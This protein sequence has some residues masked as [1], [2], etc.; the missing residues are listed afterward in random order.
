MEKVS[1]Y[2][3]RWREREGCS[4][5]S[6][7]GQIC[8]TYKTFLLIGFVF[9][10]GSSSVVQPGLEFQVSCLSLLPYYVTPAQWCFTVILLLVCFQFF[11]LE[12]SYPLWDVLVESSQDQNSWE[13]LF[14][15][16]GGWDNTFGNHCPIFI[17]QVIW[18]TPNCFKVFSNVK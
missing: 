16:V 14:P 3:L 5:S 1:F 15:L 18:L 2:N 8:S 17:N 9:E 10:I 11:P 12:V 4:V 6:L 7:V 13:S